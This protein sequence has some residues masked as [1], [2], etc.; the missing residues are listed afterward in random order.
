MCPGDSK[1]AGQTLM[2]TMK[3]RLRKNNFALVG[4]FLSLNYT[5]STSLVYSASLAMKDG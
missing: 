4:I 3:S 2:I 5:S 1:V